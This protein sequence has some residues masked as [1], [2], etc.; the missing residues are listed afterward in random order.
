ME[1][2]DTLF[3]KLKQGDISV[4]NTIIESQMK[5]VYS[6]AK[7]YY[8]IIDKDTAI[9]EG[10]IGLIKAVDRFDID[11]GFK[12][13]TFAVLCIEGSIKRYLRDT[14]ENFSIRFK[15]DDYSLLNKMNLAEEQLYAKLKREPTIDELVEYLEVDRESIIN[16]KVLKD[17][18]SMDYEVKGDSKST[19]T[20]E[21]IEDATI[22]LEEDVVNKLILEDTLSILNAKERF[23]IEKHYLEE[24]SQAEIGKIL[25][26]SQA[27][28]S[29]IET[30]AL[31]KIKDAIK[32]DT[33]KSSTLKNK[34]V[35]KENIA[36][37]D[38]KMSKSNNLA[39]LNNILFEQ[40]EKLSN[41][42]LKADELKEEIER[43]QAIAKVAAQIINTGSLVLKVKTMQDGDKIK[44]DNKDTP[45]LDSK[46]SKRG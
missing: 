38:K 42:D 2:L 28:V 12:F 30:K 41:P 25:G 10:C 24:V 17:T 37:G 31:N 21:L 45:M 46:P 32:N 13:S 20:H 40:L 43:S 33:I 7:K 16:V 11:R 35:K 39:D 29:R 9:R 5:L 15:R 6:V 4:R 36:K 18:I 14:N 44:I 1:N 8:K 23:I 26:T 3:K 22:N 34:Y 19:S 27:Q